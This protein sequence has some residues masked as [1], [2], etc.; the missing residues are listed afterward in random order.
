MLPLA[1]MPPLVFITPSQRKRSTFSQSVAA[2]AAEYCII[3]PSVGFLCVAHTDAPALSFIIAF[4]SLASSR[5]IR[6]YR[7][8]I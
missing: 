7:H 3:D 6:D 8:R 5:V 4:G 1:M 2:L